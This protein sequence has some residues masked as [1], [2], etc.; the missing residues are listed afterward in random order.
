MFRFLKQS[1]ELGKNTIKYNG[2]SKLFR[3]WCDAALTLC[4]IDARSQIHFHL[5]SETQNLNDVF[6]ELPQKV[7]KAVICN[8]S[9]CE[10][11]APHGCGLNTWPQGYDGDTILAGPLELRS[12]M[13]YLH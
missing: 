5:K 12:C 13:V 11:R 6:L 7:I 10:N 8:P 9:Q 1:V 4:L 3:S 2:N